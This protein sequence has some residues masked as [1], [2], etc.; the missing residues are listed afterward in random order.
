MHWYEMF[1]VPLTV[2]GGVFWTAAYVLIIIK[3]FKEKCYGMPF[4]ALAFNFSWEIL[5]T[6]VYKPSYPQ[7]YVNLVW[8]LFDTLILYQFL[9]YGRKNNEYGITLRWFYP[10]VAVVFIMA[11]LHTWTMT[12][13]FHSFDGMYPSYTMNLTMSI[14]FVV[15]YF[16]RPTLA[17]QSWLIA[18]L[19]LLGTLFFSLLSFL[20]Q[21]EKPFL[22]FLYVATLAFDVCYLVLVVR[23]PLR[24]KRM[25]AGE[26]TNG[27]R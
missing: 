18:L 10:V 1:S 9:R 8:F 11:F 15:F 7:N 25:A 21:P 17:G 12:V 6:F 5:F 19:K 22:D 4:I 13:E 23:H 16:R 14:L 26:I 20:Y 27:I 24:C 3:G 2:G